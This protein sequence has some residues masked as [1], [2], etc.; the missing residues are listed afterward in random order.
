MDLSEC[1]TS[2]R[3][4]YMK[5]ASELK[6]ENRFFVDST[7]LELFDVIISQSKFTVDENVELYRGRINKRDDTTPFTGEEIGMPKP[8][9]STS[10]GRANPYGI[11]YMYLSQNPETVIAELRPNIG[12]L[13]SVGQFRLTTNKEVIRLGNVASI[14]GSINDKWDSLFVSNFMMYL[15]ISFSR[16]ID[17]NKKELEYLPSQYFSEYC[18]TNGYDGIMFLSSV[19]DREYENNYNYVFF[20]DLGI[21]YKITEVYYVDS[22]KYSSFIPN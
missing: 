22:I 14:S 3:D 13:I 17:S 9:I 16:P 19:M 15:I 21:K 1:L 10:H 8:E 20:N 2:G 5:F 11:N 6:K 7:Y 18:K 12:E 4:F